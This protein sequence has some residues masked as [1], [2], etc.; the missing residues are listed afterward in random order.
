MVGE[1]KP[2]AL[3]V[4][5]ED[6][7]YALPF[8]ERRFSLVERGYTQ[9]ETVMVLERVSATERKSSVPSRLIPPPYFPGFPLIQDSAVMVCVPEAPIVTVAWWAPPLLSWADT[10]SAPSSIPQ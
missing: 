8:R 4:P 2:V 5:P 9:K 6:D 10:A 1:V 3:I 7:I